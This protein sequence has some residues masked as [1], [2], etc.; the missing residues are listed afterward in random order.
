MIEAAIFDL[1][2]TLLDTSA[3]ADARRRGEWAVVKTRLDRVRPFGLAGVPVEEIPAQ[4]KVE[5][6]KIGILTHSPGWY[7]SAL[8]ERF[9]IRAD[10]LVTGSDGFPPK[11]DPTSLKAVAEELGVAISNC[12]YVGDLD[13]DAAA[14][15]AAGATSIGVSWSKVAPG[16]W[17]RWWPDVAVSKPERLLE[18]AEIDRLRPLAEAVLARVEPRWHWGT[19]MRVEQQIGALGRYFTPEDVD[20]HPA[21]ALSNLVLGAKDDAEKGE[22]AA[23]IFAR[24]GGRPS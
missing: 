22:Q 13:T 17:R 2:D 19:V 7:A 3:L 11:P 14:A 16:T 8:L 9:K 20:R 1:D 4:L 10:A 18:L 12:V 24:L 15:A 21:H 6:L 23:E 5:G